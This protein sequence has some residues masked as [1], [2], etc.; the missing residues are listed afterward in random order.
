[1]T[2]TA[3]IACEMNEGT[4]ERKRKKREKERRRARVA[5]NCTQNA[6]DKK[7]EG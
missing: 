5:N 2:A 7:G 3:R 4:K 6:T 1:M